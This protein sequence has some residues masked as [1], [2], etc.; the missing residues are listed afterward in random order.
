MVRAACSK[1]KKSQRTSEVSALPKT[2][3]R[4]G[5]TTTHA[6]QY[7]IILIVEIVLYCRCRI[8]GT[9]DGH[10]QSLMGLEHR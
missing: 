2:V 7:H 8:D 5:P 4:L 3:N 1:C 6:S 9:H 10:V